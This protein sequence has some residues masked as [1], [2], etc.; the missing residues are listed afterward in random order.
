MH[1]KILIIGGGMAGLSAGTYLQMN[2]FD[3]EIFELNQVPGGV[4]TSWKRGDYTV[5]WCIHWLVGS[6][7]SDSFYD[8]WSELINMSQIEIV[9]H[10]EYAAVEDA[11]GNL[12]HLYTNLDRLEAEL[13]EKAPEDEKKISEFVRAC[14]KLCDLNLPN[15]QPF[16]LANL[17]RKMR[18]MWKM[19]PYL[20]VLGKYSRISTIDYSKGFKNPLLRKAVANL[21]EPEIPILFCMMT[22]AWMHKKAAGYPV[23]GSMHFARRIADR[24]E[25]LGGVF[26][27]GTRVEK[28]EVEAGC[29]TGIRLA[30]GA[31]LR[32]DIVISAADGHS[33]LYDMLDGKFISPKFEE[34]YNRNET[35]PSLVFV[36]LGVGR[37]FHATPHS[38]LFHLSS[39]F[40][41]DPQTVLNDLYIRVHNFDPTLAPYGKTL[42]TSMIETRN[43]EYWV[44]LQKNDLVRYAA[45]KQRIA[46]TLIDILEDKFG[47][48]RDLVEMTDVTTPATIIGFTNNWKGSFEGW[49]LTPE[50]GFTQLPSTLPD[51]DNFYMCGHWVA[52]GGGLPAA[53]ISG[54]NVAQ[55]ICAKENI[56]FEICEPV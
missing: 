3:T 56:Q 22:F 14:R 26:H 12:L 55:L 28:I 41:I 21:F 39:P 50:T 1:K 33:T 25:H 24:Y 29:A 17:W 20:G 18:L 38:Y 30:D 10:E 11:A 8:R 49:L 44:N 31:I 43:W 47:N 51:L 2:G 42:I 37:S 19:L 46:Q 4:C 23:G 52:I 13:L 16:E 45:E 5:D 34:F 9:D 36:A 27:Y 32:G 54:R 15:D 53:M 40:E 48:V 35:F 6:G 7:S